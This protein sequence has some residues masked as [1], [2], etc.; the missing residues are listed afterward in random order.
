[1]SNTNFQLEKNE[2]FMTYYKCIIIDRPIPLQIRNDVLT[3]VKF[4]TIRLAIF[5]FIM[6]G[7]IVLCLSK[8][9]K[10]H[11]SHR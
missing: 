8:G 4:S 5:F 2:S 7:D 6:N 10:I 1:M 9:M 3:S 11:S